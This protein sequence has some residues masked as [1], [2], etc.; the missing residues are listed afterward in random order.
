MASLVDRLGLQR[1][2][3]VSQTRRIDCPFSK[4]HGVGLLRLV[5][6]SSAQYMCKQ[7]ERYECVAETLLF[8]RC[9]VI[10]GLTLLLNGQAEAFEFSAERT[11]RIG[12]RSIARLCMLPMIVGSLNRRSLKEE[13]P[14]PSSVKIEAKPGYCSNERKRTRKFRLQRI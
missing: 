3:I 9:M 10:A 13:S 11:M 8:I 6:R 1:P 14:P 4:Y 5:V 12:E 2:V 7:R